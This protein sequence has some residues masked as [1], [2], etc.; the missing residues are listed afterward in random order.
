MSI[1]GD[2]AR[3]GLARKVGL[4]LG[5]AAVLVTRLIA[6]TDAA[7]SDRASREPVATDRRL[8]ELFDE[9]L[10]EGAQWQAKTS[11]EIV[12]DG[13]GFAG[14][15]WAYMHTRD[16]RVS[17]SG[18][19]ISIRENP[20]PGEYRYLSFAWQ[21][22]GGGQIA[23]QIDR[24]DTKDGQRQRGELHG[25]RFD[26]GEGPAVEGKSLRLSEVVPS[27]WTEVT[28]DLWQDFG[29]FTITGLTFMSIGGRDAAFDRIYLAR[30][31]TDF[32]AMPPSYRQSGLA[33]GSGEDGPVSAAPIL[34]AQVAT[35]V[36]LSASD[37]AT[38]ASSKADPGGDAP[39]V[40]HSDVDT[41]E[42]SIDWGQQIMAGGWTMVPLI[43]LSMAGLVIG[44]QR[45]LTIR[46]S[47]I[48]P[49]QL[50]PA[51]RR[52]MDDGD[53][54]KALAECDRRPSTLAEALRF[55]IEHRQNDVQVV[56][57]AAGDIAARDIRD[58]MSRIYP[59]SVIGA[60]APLLGLLGTIIGMIEA[61][62]L[63]SIYG[64]EG[65]ATILS[66]S[67][68]KALITTAAGLVIAIPAIAM[69]YF[70]RNRLMRITSLIEIALE[71]LIASV[72]L[73]KDVGS[74]EPPAAGK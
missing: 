52:A 9:T 67:I 54:S 31:L 10:P 23:L 42:V 53:A 6:E 44:V 16:G 55:V 20:E 35:P 51:V 29:D 25:Y 27:Q 58:Q 72:Y 34:P 64:D 21:K 13:G 49:Q 46:V 4:W 30:A 12:R 33:K 40:L 1:S 62:A 28:R 36:D 3:F 26:A 39:V 56:N 50:L 59:L 63:V 32:E 71:D 7:D 48:A 15:R 69:Y 2:L 11:E 61:F 38:T 60:L 57:Q 24:D 37:D 66:G 65:G 43:V 18:L 70:I 47:L 19:S 68:S 73:K 5:L 14:E 22:W 8:L 17:S 41:Q 74:E 45:L